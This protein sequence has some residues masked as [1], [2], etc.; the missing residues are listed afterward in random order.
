MTIQQVGV[1]AEEAAEA[2]RA[3][4]K[5]HFEYPG[6]ALARPIPNTLAGRLSVGEVGADGEVYHPEGSYYEAIERVGS[7]WDKFWGLI[8]KELIK[9][10][11]TD[12]TALVIGVATTAYF[13]EYF[14]K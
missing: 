11:I 10:K 1:S 8:I 12:F 14:F 13:I 7:E 3:F 2:F 5:V 9:V 6:W 4:G